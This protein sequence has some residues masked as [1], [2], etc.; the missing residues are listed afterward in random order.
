VIAFLVGTWRSLVAHLLGV[1]GVA[2]SNLAVPTNQFQEP[3]GQH[4]PPV[5]ARSEKPGSLVTQRAKRHGVRE[6]APALV[7]QAARPWP[8]ARFRPARRLPRS[9]ATG[10]PLKIAGCTFNGKDKAWNDENSWLHHLELRRWR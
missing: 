1:Q 8:E 9:I 3:L 5:T 4:G 7:R 2:S 6:L 10:R